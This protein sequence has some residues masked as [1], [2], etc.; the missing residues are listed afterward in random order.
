MNIQSI[1]IVAP[2][3]KCVNKC[4]FCVSCMH[5]SPYENSFD[6]IQYRKRIKFASNNFINTS[7][8]TG[9]NG[10]ILQ[11]PEFLIN[12]RGVL[13]SEH[14]PFPNV[15]IQTTGVLL[16]NHEGRD[17]IALLK[18]LGVNTISLSV[19][20]IFNSDNNWDIIGAPRAQRFDL[21]DLC[22]L[23]KS[24]K[25]NLRLSLNMVNVYDNYEEA[26][27]LAQC[28]K[29]GADQVTFRKLYAAKDNSDQSNW[30]KSNAC[31]PFTL[32]RIKEYI[33]GTETFDHGFVNA[34]GRPLYRLPFGSMAY[35]IM[36]MSTV[37]DDNCM[38]K[39]ENEKLKYVILRENGKLY[40]QWDDEGSLI[41]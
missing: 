40:S 39:D 7:I 4:K 20:D 25:F 34:N 36:G 6:P 14:H 18:S 10:E 8:I 17:N 37:I 1:S 11:N 9:D 41:F 27:I 15:E 19:S 3:K 33:A 32:N 31:Q 2:T 26:E 5:D 23:I 16:F 29:L 13:E 30:V 35:S 22:N 12:L 28:K 21:L 38:S 24:K